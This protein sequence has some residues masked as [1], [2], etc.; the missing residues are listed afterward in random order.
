[1]ATTAIKVQ[2]KNMLFMT[3]E[4][5]NGEVDV[6]IFL[7]DDDFLP[8]GTPSI[9]YC[10]KSE[11]EYHKELREQANEKGHLIINFCTNPEWNPKIE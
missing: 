8:V 6:D 3:A 7:A 5:E 4:K 2:G 9:G 10:D 11:E 1:M